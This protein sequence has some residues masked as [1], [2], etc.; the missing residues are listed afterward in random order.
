[1]SVI[2]DIKINKEPGCTDPE[3]EYCFTDGCG[4]VS[5]ELSKLINEK[6]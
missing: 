1:V 2:P 3:G 4:N 5:I 6:L